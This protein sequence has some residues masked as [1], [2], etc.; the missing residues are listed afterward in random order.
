MVTDHCNEPQELCPRRSCL[1]LSLTYQNLLRNQAGG[2]RETAWRQ[3]LEILYGLRRQPLS[4]NM[5]NEIYLNHPTFGLLYQ[6]CLLEENRE[7]F[8]TLYAQRLFFLVSS[9]SEQISFA[10]ISRSEGKLLL[11]NRLRSLRRSGSPTD[12]EALYAVYRRT[13]Y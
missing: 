6:I 11:E 5:G 8:T 13:F 12:Y 3:S 9:T 2:R 1:L 10:P 7:L 4:S